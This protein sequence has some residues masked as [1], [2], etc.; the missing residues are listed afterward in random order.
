VSVYKDL[1]Y[2]DLKIRP[3]AIWSFLLYTGYL[4]PVEVKKDEDDLWV[5]N[6]AVPNRE[7]LTVMKSAMQHWWKDIHLPSFDARPLLQALWN[8]DIASIERETRTIMDDS[9]SVNDAKEDFYHGMMVGVL[10]TVGTVKSN[11][12]YGEGRP[13]I[14]FK[15][16]N[17]AIILELKCLLPSV[18]NKMPLEQQFIKV[19]AMM[20][21]LLDEAETQ[22]KTRYYIQGLMFEDQNIT[23]VKSYAVCFCKKRCMVREVSV[24]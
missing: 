10:R 7:I 22:F 9:V 13:D 5:A 11:R 16:R 4:K 15:D 12:E 24:G 14:V 17:R 20:S 6:V 23:E 3:D 18:I 21:E 1:S 8:G 2:R 19:P